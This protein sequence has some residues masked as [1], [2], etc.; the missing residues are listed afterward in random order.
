[1]STKMYIINYIFNFCNVPDNGSVEIL[2]F[3]LIIYKRK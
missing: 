2:V 3:H 1:M